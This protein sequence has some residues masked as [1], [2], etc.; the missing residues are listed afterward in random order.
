MKLDYDSVITPNNDLAIADTKEIDAK[1]LLAMFLE[2]Y[3]I[4][5]DCIGKSKTVKA[6]YK[7]VRTLYD[8][9]SNQKIRCILD[10]VP[11]AICHSFLKFL[12]EC[13]HIHV[14]ID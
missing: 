9:A 11:A 14:T 8:D 2:S 6:F 10:S 3:S 5:D 7:A 4:L 13:P 12:A 1:K